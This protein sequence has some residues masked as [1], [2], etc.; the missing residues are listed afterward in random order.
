M[1]PA[2]NR[3]CIHLSSRGRPRMH[4]AQKTSDLLSGGE[5]YRVNIRLVDMIDLVA[6]VA[7]YVDPYRTQVTAFILVTALIVEVVFA[8]RAVK[9]QKHW[10]TKATA[11]LVALLLF[12]SF[13]YKA[14][15]DFLA[16]FLFFLYCVVCH[17]CH[18][19]C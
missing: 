18:N 9:R 1:S 12:C 3:Y 15:N 19:D 8:F 10:K 2:Q 6:F 4:R 7:N 11:T 16:G 13:F 14:S 17:S 5:K